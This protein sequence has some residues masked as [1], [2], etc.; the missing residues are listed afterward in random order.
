MGFTKPH[1][2]LA[3]VALIAPVLGPESLVFFEAGSS[4]CSFPFSPSCFRQNPH[5]FSSD[6][7]RIQLDI[8]RRPISPVLSLF[9]EKKAK[10]LSLRQLSQACAALRCRFPSN[11]VTIKLKD[12]ASK[13]EEIRQRIVFLAL[14]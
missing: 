10:S 14:F 11:E 8:R 6:K 12:D 2:R 4:A 1:H 3:S 13:V 9:S 7:T 5:T